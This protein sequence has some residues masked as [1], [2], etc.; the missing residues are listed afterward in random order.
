MESSSTFLF[1]LRSILDDSNSLK[2][3]VCFTIAF[4]HGS[5]SHTLEKGL[6]A[7]THVEGQGIVA[8]P[9]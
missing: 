5:L 4:K 1:L 9:G 6:C 8:R 3:I 7:E 2:V